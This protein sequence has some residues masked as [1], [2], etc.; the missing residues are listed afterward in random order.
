MNNSELLQYIQKLE[1][2][3]AKLEDKVTPFK[4]PTFEQVSYYFATKGRPDLAEDFYQFYESKGWMVGR[5]KM[6][7]W[8]MAASRWIKMNSKT[9]LDD[10]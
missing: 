6:K 3:V 10:I 2:R 8:Q 1:A 4:K 7:S 9:F 5:N